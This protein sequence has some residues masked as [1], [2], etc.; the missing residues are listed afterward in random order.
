[1]NEDDTYNRLKRTPIEQIF[2]SIDMMRFHAVTL[3]GA[4]SPMSEALFKRVI[5]GGWTV[6]DFKAELQ[7]KIDEEFIMEYVIGQHME[8][9]P[10]DCK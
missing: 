2:G 9:I 6:E 4:R 10:K 3:I 7:R 8:F 1:M 5:A